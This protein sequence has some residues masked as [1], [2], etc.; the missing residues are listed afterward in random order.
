[1]CGWSRSARAPHGA[2]CRATV[3]PRV[4]AG[5]IAGQHAGGYLDRRAVAGHNQ[6][7]RPVS[8]STTFPSSSLARRWIAARSPARRSA[9]SPRPARPSHR[10]SGWARGP[11]RARSWRRQVLDR[12]L[13]SARVSGDVSELAAGLE[14]AQH[15]ATEL[16]RIPRSFHEDLLGRSGGSNVSN[17]IARIAGTHHCTPIA[18]W[19]PHR[20]LAQDE[21]AGQG[22]RMHGPTSKGGR[23]AHRPRHQEAPG[24]Y[25]RFPTG[26]GGGVDDS[27]RRLL[28]RLRPVAAAATREVRV[29]PTADRS[30]VRR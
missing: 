26:V 25:Q 14:Q 3:Q 15:L 22:A 13:A 20:R 9:S 16:G 10:W 18:P 17:P 27:P 30:V 24:N 6:I 2:G 12:S 21:I 8:W 1:M 5:L 23:H 29:A 19:L 28:R 7:V 11:R 4:V